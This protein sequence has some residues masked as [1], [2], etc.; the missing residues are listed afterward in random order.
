M[1]DTTSSAVRP[2]GHAA[3]EAWGLDP[4]LTFL[5][6]GSFGAVP[7]TL[8]DAAESH[9]R[10]IERNPVEGVWR[11]AIPDI[12]RNAEAVA[13]FVGGHPDRTAFVPNATAGI[14][15]MLDALDL[16]PG[17]EVLHIDQGY[18]AVWQTIL[19]AGR[20]RGLE[21]RRVELPWPIVDE[22]QILERFDA[23]MTPRTSLLVLDQ[24]TSPTAIRLPI[25]S[26]IDLARNRGVEVIVDG[27]HAPGMLDRPAASSERAAAWTGNLH[28]WPCALRGTAAL[29]VR[30]DLETIVKPSITSHFLDVSFSAEFDW[31]GTFDPTPWLLAADAIA[32][33]DRFGGW[34]AVRSRNHDLAVEAHR[35]L[36][37][38]FAVQAMSPLDGRFLGSMATILLPPP[39]QPEQGGPPLAAGH[40]ATDDRGR[41]DLQIDPIQ[42]ML[43][44][45][46]RIEI[47]VMVFAG[48][49]H[50]RISVHVYNQA[51]DYRRLADAIHEITEST[52]TRT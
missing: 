43:H 8:L 18:N 46:H 26:I 40:G 29:C 17:T 12:R 47:P 24:V 33:M 36:C 44:E 9:R 21:P 34:D 20:Q 27:A 1:P 7:R 23:S 38:S 50:V 14:N 10:G 19:R 41:L 39:L 35:T 45:R 25:Q 22:T 37:E 3:R 13:A 15:A 42:K 32:F 11:H 31:Q 28:K 16:A 52:W 5:N 30:E 2:F 48:R 49:R 51:S 6:H 4:S